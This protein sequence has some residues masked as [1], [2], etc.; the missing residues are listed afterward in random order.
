MAAKVL[1]SALARAGRRRA[2]AAI[3][4]A[5]CASTAFLAG[6]TYVTADLNTGT[7]EVWTFLTSRQDVNI[8]R[9][10]DGSIRWTAKE[11]N[12]NAD[13]AAALLNATSVAAKLAGAP[14]V[15]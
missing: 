4:V 7:V 9:D 5:G 8:G 6:C 3:L 12:A 11:S 10:S 14:V 13:L 15:P 2:S 1:G